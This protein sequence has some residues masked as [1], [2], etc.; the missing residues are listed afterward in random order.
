MRV[1]VV[2]ALLLGLAVC[3]TQPT[4]SKSPSPSASPAASPSPSPSPPPAPSPSPAAPPFVGAVGLGGCPAPAADQ[5]PLGTP[6]PPG[7]GVHS[8][9]SLKWSGCGSVTV[10]PGSSRFITGNNWQ[11]GFAATCPPGLDYGAGGMGTSVKFAE[12]LVDSSAGPDEQDAAGPWTDSGGGIMA[13]G[14]NFQVKITALDPRCRW[15]VAV[16]PAN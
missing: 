5:H 9:A 14:G 8:D 3:G 2:V 4:A 16:Y 1:G 15:T 12:L 7:A 10:P 13:H 11:L 6:G